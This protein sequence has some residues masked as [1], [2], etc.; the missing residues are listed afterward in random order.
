MYAKV[1]NKCVLSPYISE[2]VHLTVASN[3]LEKGAG[4]SVESKLQY[5]IKYKDMHRFLVE[6]K[7]HNLT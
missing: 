4:G 5:A 6:I 2:K 3:G 1:L 7:I